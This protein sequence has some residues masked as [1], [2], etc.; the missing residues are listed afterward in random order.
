M[1]TTLPYLH[2]IDY[3]WLAVDDMQQVA[4]FVTA[5]EGPIPSSALPTSEADYE[6]E[7]RLL[8]L[9]ECSS[10]H[11][12]TK[13]PRPDDYVAMAKR[14]LFAFDWGDIHRKQVDCKGVYELI[15]APSQAITLEQLPAELRNI[16]SVTHLV[17][18]NFSLS[19][20]SG[21]KV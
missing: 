7:E 20:Q 11:L 3:A 1:E 14:G 10:F 5:G 2:G 17:G 16:A 9:P 21:I 18:V 12:H 8:A 6:I 13:Y 15:A 19:A 4:V